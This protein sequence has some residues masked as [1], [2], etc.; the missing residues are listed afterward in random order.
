MPHLAEV[1]T[2]FTSNARQIPVMFRKLA[3]EIENPTDHGLPAEG[4]PTCAVVVVFD[5][6]TGRHNT[7]GWG[8][9]DIGKS[10]QYLGVALRVLT[11][12]SDGGSLWPIPRGGVK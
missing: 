3:D 2:L 12:L 6:V 7:Y 10:I 8:D 1:K 11:K 9:T 5:P 4:S